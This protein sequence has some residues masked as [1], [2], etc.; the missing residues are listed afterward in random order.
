MGKFDVWITNGNEKAHYHHIVHEIGH[1][2]DQDLAENGQAGII[3]L[4][5]ETFLASGM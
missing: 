1:T 3:F 2:E 4:M 5:V